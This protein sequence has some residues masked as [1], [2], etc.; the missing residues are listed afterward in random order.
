MKKTNRS[1][2]NAKIVNLEVFENRTPVTVSKI[3]EFLGNDWKEITINFPSFGGLTVEET[4]HFIN[5]LNEAVKEAEE[6]SK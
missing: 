1:T 3:K 5:V 4:K 2:E 6:M